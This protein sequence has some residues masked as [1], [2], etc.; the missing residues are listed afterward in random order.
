M[1]AFFAKFVIS[2]FFSLYSSVSQ[3]SSI[4]YL[5]F[6]FLSNIQYTSLQG[7]CSPS[8]LPKFTLL[9]VTSTQQRFSLLARRKYE[10][11]LAKR[12][13]L[14]LERCPTTSPHFSTATVYLPYSTA[15]FLVL[16]EL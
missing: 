2:Q 1:E 14:P 12:A 10:T 13:D 7:I 8:P 16:V 3:I 11:V 15:Y 6:I 4:K 9:P 5:V